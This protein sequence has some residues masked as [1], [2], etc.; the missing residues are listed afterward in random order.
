MRRIDMKTMK[1]TM[2]KTKMHPS[3]KLLISRLYWLVHS[4][5]YV[6]CVGIYSA[7]IDYFIEI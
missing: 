3:R 7:R 4:R 1:K 6:R 5:E 2:Q